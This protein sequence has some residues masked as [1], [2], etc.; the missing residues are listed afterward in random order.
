MPLIRII[1]LSKSS[2]INAPQLG[3]GPS[4]Y[5]FETRDIRFRSGTCSRSHTTT[6]RFKKNCDIHF[7]IRFPLKRMIFGSGRAPLQ[8]SYYDSP[9]EWNCA[10]FAMCGINFIM[11]SNLYLTKMKDNI[12]YHG[13]QK[14]I[15]ALIE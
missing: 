7:D 8:I 10:F 5:I 13:R 15:H 11:K 4:S 12:C 3:I 6:L 2:K 9:F 1:F 14:S